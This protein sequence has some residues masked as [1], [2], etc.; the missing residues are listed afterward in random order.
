MALLVKCLPCKY[1]NMIPGTRTQVKRN[2]RLYSLRSTK[3]P[4][5]EKDQSGCIEICQT[6]LLGKELLQAIDLVKCWAVCSSS[7]SCPYFL[8]RLQTKGLHVA[9][10]F[11]GLL[12]DT[13]LITS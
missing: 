2:F 4:K 6:A 12:E 7:L 11:Q 9:S 5:G 8:Y 3:P 1:H 13:E 10:Q